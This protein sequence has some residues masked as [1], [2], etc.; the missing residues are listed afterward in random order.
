MKIDGIEP[1]SSQPLLLCIEDEDEDTE[2]RQDMACVST[3]FLISL[4][5][6]EPEMLLDC[7]R[8]SFQFGAHGIEVV[9]GVNESARTGHTCQDPVWTVSSF[10]AQSGNN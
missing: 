9:V 10:V 1:E 6:G 3:S 7:L 4:K 2:T 8:D 5:A